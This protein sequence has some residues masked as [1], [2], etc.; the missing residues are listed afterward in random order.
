MV[1]SKEYMALYRMKNRSAPSLPD[2]VLKSLG[3]DDKVS[4]D[5][6]DYAGMSENDVKDFLAGKSY[7]VHAT[8][9][10]NGELIYIESQYDKH[11]VNYTDHP[12]MAQYEQQNPGSAGSF[13]DFHNHPM[14]SESSI[15]IFSPRDLRTYSSEFQ[16][17][18]FVGMTIPA[19]KY[20]NSFSVK[21]A[22]G[23]YFELKYNGNTSG[24]RKPSGIGRAYKN[25]YNIYSNAAHSK[26]KKGEL[27]TR[28]DTAEYISNKLS[29]WLSANAQNYG[30][31]YIRG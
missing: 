19:R 17:S 5:V 16:D 18:K 26:K 12:A 10:P 30:F 2:S 29:D 20:I 28:K 4:L 31:E 7:E 23:R 1:K 24:K 15:A 25:A 13:R 21:T 22:D 8:F 14:S 9:A 11:T 3:A 27:K 6:S